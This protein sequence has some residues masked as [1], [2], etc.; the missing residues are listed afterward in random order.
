[1]VFA[2]RRLPRK[3]GMTGLLNISIGRPPIGQKE[4]VSLCPQCL[5]GE[6]KITG[7]TPEGLGKFFFR[8]YWMVFQNWQNA[9][10]V[11]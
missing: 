11:F 5:Y 7:N 2:H 8:D 4:I 3:G 10:N 6:K 9:D 1:M